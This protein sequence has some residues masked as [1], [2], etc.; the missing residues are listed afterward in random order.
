[1]NNIEFGRIG[2]DTAAEM[3]KAK[4]YEIL[5]RNYRCSTGE[6]DIIAARDFK[7]SFIEVKTRSSCF[8]G[9]PCEAVDRRKQDGIKKTAANYLREEKDR[10]CV[11]DSIGFDVVEIVVNHIENAF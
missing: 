8:Y 5:K 7:L 11:Y 3:L 2:E 9:R 6:I 4:G 10:N 1:M